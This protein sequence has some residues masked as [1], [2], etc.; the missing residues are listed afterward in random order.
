MS[1]MKSLACIF[2]LFVAFGF[3]GMALANTGDYSGDWQGSWTSFVGYSGGLSFSITQTGTSISGTLSLFSTECGNF[4]GLSLGGTV[5][6]NDT[7]TF[8][9]SAYCPSDDEIYELEY[10]SGAVSGNI[11]SGTYTI[12]EAGVYYYYSGTFDVTRTVN[13]ITATA[14]PG[15]GG[16]ISP[17]GTVHVDAGTSLTFTITPNAGYSISD[18]LVDGV[19]VGAVPSYTFSNIQANHTIAASFSISAPV[20]DFTA[21]PTSGKSPLT[22]NFS[23]QSTGNVISR[24]WS[25]GDGGTSTDQNPSHTYS[26]PGIYT[27]SLT[28]SGPGGS[29][30][31][32]K[33]D[34]IT[35]EV[36][37][38]PGVP[39]LLLDDE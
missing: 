18:V 34:Y 33:P 24:S 3:C 23:D 9:G 2:A 37:G 29:D 11:F 39:L 12:Y 17:S 27:V 28:V 35:V 38:N 10:T 5:Y 25:F 1:K 4:V 36:V 19:S 20:A 14:S 30:T 6:A 31:E 16:S 7:A 8:Y 15:Q 26:I 22:V 13:I 32:T 21:N